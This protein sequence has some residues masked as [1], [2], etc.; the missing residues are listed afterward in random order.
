MTEPRFHPRV[1][2][3]FS[4]AAHMYDRHALF[5]NYAAGQLLEWI[6]SE[7]LSS[8]PQWKPCRIFEAGCGTGFLS[9]PLA[10]TFPEAELT[11]TDLSSG[12]LGMV[13][14]KLLSR[15]GVEFCV[16]DFN[17]SFPEST[18]R[19]DLLVSAMAL[20][21]AASLPDVLSRFRT[22]LG[23]EGRLFFSVPLEGTFREMRKIF[24]QEG[25][26]YPGLSLPDPDEL[27]KTLLGI[28]GEAGQVFLKRDSYEETFSSV[29]DFWKTLRNTGTGNASGRPV[30]LPHL[31]HLLRKH[32]GKIRVNYE[33]ALVKCSNY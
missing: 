32:G 14:S 17:G 23:G 21:W 3:N 28:F 27:Y 33:Y 8:F 6:R 7:S 26:P 9:V 29:A 10:E 2:E 12:M 18:G 25:I 15:S 24:E 30:P 1:L 13:R 16:Y 20:Q 31:R 5:Q 11:V 22:M 19:Y 4:G